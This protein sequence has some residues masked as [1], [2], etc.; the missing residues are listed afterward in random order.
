MAPK[1]N[2]QLGSVGE[3]MGSLCYPSFS[4]GINMALFWLFGLLNVFLPAGRLDKNVW[5]KFGV[6]FQEVALGPVK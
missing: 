6:L 2:D 5:L 1:C 3:W 4:K